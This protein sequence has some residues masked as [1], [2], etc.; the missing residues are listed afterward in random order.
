MRLLKLAVGN[1][2][3]VAQT[4]LQLNKL[5]ALV[6]TN[7]YGKT[8]LLEAV[9]FGFDFI[10]SSPKERNNM[11]RWTRGIP[12][13]PTLAGNDFTFSVEFDCP[14]LGEYRFV[15]YGFSFSWFNDQDTGA[16]IT[17][18]I[19]DMR[20]TESVRYT[21]YLKR[22]KG[23]YKGGKSKTNFRKL[24][25]AKDTLAIDALSLIDD[26]E[27]AEVIVAIK[28][29]RYR[30]CNTLELDKSFKPNP[31]VFDFGSNSC[32]DFD[33]NDIPRAI[34]VLMKE[35]PEQ[36]HLFLETIYDLFPEFT[37]IDLRSYAINS[38]NVTAKAIMLS[39]GEGVE[40]KPEIPY[41]IRD[42]I[43]KLIIESKHLNQPI[44]ME[45]MS[46]GTKRILWLIANAVFSS[47]YN[48]CFLGVDEIET[49]IHPKMIHSLLSSLSEILGDA[50]ML[51]T[52]HSPY[53]IQ[54]LKPESLY[55]GV[56]NEDGIA[57]FRKIRASKLKQL[58][59]VARDL[60]CSVGEYLFEL[61]SGDDDSASILSA[62]L[63][64]S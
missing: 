51:I 59:S 56:P 8:N 47:H 12:L 19:I 35:N 10:T 60:E 6:S 40:D 34:S 26:L 24:N 64:D 7:N 23:L 21:S 27:I 17:N 48:T 54:Y 4:T 41:R 42:E 16:K 22:D 18:E 52:S 57:K 31:I 5:T 50:I 44:S 45:Y 58:V 63:E 29:L 14:E 62:Y 1:F 13:S 30:M 43:Y 49:S 15:R 28:A 9:Q 33:D 39:A 36:Y 61:M 55:V 53:L 25:L 11:M 46:T 20:P 3:N 2:K 38:E 37:R 32:I